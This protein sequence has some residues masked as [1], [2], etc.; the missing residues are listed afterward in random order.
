MKELLERLEAQM[1]AVAGIT[2][3]RRGNPPRAIHKIYKDAGL[4]SKLL[5]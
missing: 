3:I 1:H 2:G 4:K 5:A